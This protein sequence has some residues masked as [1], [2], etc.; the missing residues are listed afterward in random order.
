MSPAPEKAPLTLTPRELL[1]IFPEAPPPSLAERLFAAPAA[2][3]AAQTLRGSD[4][5]T[6]AAI[7]GALGDGAARLCARLYRLLVPIARKFAPLIVLLLANIGALCAPLWLALATAT[8][9]IFIVAS[10][11]GSVASQL[12]SRGMVA[13]YG[14]RTADADPW[15]GAARYAQLARH[16]PGSVLLLHREGDGMCSCPAPTCAGRSADFAA[17]EALLA[18][19]TFHAPVQM[20]VEILISWTAIVTFA[21]RTWNTPWSASLASLYFAASLAYNGSQHLP[22]SVTGHPPLGLAKRLRHR[23]VVVL[24]GDLLDR[25]RA[26]AIEGAA[27]DPGEAQPEPVPISS[28][29]YAALHDTLA[30]SWH[31]HRVRASF[32]RGLVAFF[33]VLSLLAALPFAFRGGCIPLWPPVCAALQ[34]LKLLRD[35]VLV[36]SWNA[37]IATVRTAYACAASSLLRL[38]TPSA[39]AHAALLS[40]FAAEDPRAR[41]LGAAVD[42]S[43]VRTAAATS[44]T[45][46]LGLYTVARGAGL[47]FGP[48]TACGG[49]AVG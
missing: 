40:A 7:D 19:F 8:I 28:E 2:A 11:V 49:V 32:G 37:G 17:A 1:A 39:R 34:A 33:L 5:L 48:Q 16:E 21:P 15:A 18:T 3:D 20:A 31:A 43:V 13:Q 6:E 42:H 12:S 9:A 29:P 45:V 47:A 24:L 38:G 26:A 25:E 30:S 22:M 35:A 10:L 14:A 46:G 41:F 36:A 27:M 4:P 44:F 23:A